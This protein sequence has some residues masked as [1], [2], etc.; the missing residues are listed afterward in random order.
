MM[1]VHQPIDLQNDLLLVVLSVVG[2]VA[3]SI[4]V[5]LPEPGISRTETG[6]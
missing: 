1:A 6:G 4:V 2:I 3:L 5:I